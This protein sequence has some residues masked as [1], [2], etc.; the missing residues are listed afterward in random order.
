MKS[1]SANALLQFPVFTVV[2]ILVFL[3]IL[4]FVLRGR[5]AKPSWRALLLAA[6]LI[7]GGSMFLGKFGANLGL[8]WWIYYSIPMLATVLGPPLLFTMKRGETLNY[9]ILSLLS[10]PAIH[11]VFSFFL[12]WKEYMPFIP[13]RS[14]NELLGR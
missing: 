6:F 9:L 4:R 12:G 5:E 11:L 1:G 8:P 10:A 7:I 13:M 3:A 2:S 14:L